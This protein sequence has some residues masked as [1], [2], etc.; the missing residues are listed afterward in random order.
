MPLYNPLS[1]AEYNA[2]TEIQYNTLSEDQIVYFKSNKVLFDIYGR[3]AF[4]PQACDCSTHS[5]VAAGC[6]F[7]GTVFQPSCVTLR[8]FDFDTTGCPLCDVA[9]SGD[10]PLTLY[11]DGVDRFTTRDSAW[12]VWGGP[13]LDAFQTSNNIQVYADIKLDTGT[14]RWKLHVVCAHFVNVLGH[15]VPTF[16]DVWIGEKTT[17]KTPVGTYLRTGGSDTTP[18]LYVQ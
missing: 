7:P 11:F 17:G 4:C 5:G 3:V 1:E 14:C 8:R 16:Y 13:D 6:V 9:A 18:Q 15:P 2:L 10:L 12:G